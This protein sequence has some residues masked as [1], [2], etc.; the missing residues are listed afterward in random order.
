MPLGEYLRMSTEPCDICGAIAAMN[1]RLS[2]NCIDH[3][4]ETGAIRGTLCSN[5]NIALGLFAESVPRLNGAISYIESH[6]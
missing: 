6:Q 1:G 5:C 4:H 3:D 2:K